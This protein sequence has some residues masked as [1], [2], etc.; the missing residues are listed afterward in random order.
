MFR[1]VPGNIMVKKTFK[2]AKIGHYHDIPSVLISTNGNLMQ[3]ILSKTPENGNFYCKM[4]VRVLRSTKNDDLGM[5]NGIFNFFRKLHF[6]GFWL[7]F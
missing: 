1:V 4:C 5:K 2:S 3:E 7:V 6:S